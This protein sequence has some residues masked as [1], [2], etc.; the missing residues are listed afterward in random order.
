M[1]GQKKR[2]DHITELLKTIKNPAR[3]RGA[4]VISSLLESV[5]MCATYQREKS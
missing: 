2:E 1:S 3:K 4:A 5:C